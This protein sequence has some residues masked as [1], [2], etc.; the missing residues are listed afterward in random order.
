MIPVQIKSLPADPLEGIS[1]AEFGAQLRSGARSAEATTLAYLE[2]ITLL[3]PRLHAFVHVATGQAVAQARAVDR[4]LAAGTD[5]GPLMGVPV[6]VKDLFTVE[7][8]PLPKCGSNVDIGDLVGPEGPFVRRLKQA[9]CV[10]LGKTRMTEFAFGL[11]NLIHLTPWNPCDPAVH[12]MPGGSSSGSAVAL[13]AALCAFSV[14]SDT[15]GS[16]RQPAALC[17]AFGLKTTVG[18]WS[19]EGVFPLSTTMDTIGTFTRSAEDAALVFAVMS[20]ETTSPPRP[21]KGL[22]LGRPGAHFFD[23]LGRG[24]A[25]ATERALRQLEAAGVVIVPIELPEAAE[26]DT[27]FAPIVAVELLATLG[28]ERFASAKDTLDPIVWDRGAPALRFLAV[29]YVRQRRRQEVLYHVA[30][31]RMLGLDAWISA[32]SP[33]VALPVGDFQ[34]PTKAAAWI[35]RNTHYT[36]PIN[37][38]GQCAASIPLPGSGLPVGLQVV[39]GAGRDSDLIGISQG[40]E[41]LLGRRTLPAASEFLRTPTAQPPGEARVD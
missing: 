15:G 27:I 1:I 37:L 3:D 34:D 7:G 18:H 31:E 2:R 36:R 20:G 29:D 24:V 25:A 35:R 12:R 26:I 13:A 30:T 40:I 14:G 39:C 8:M 11:F 19:T 22:R 41:A 32:T 4:L 33:D 9:G 6:A 10:I 16:V 38:F 17:G 5:L 23:G 28:A 21:L